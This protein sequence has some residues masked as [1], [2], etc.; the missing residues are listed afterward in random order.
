ME[1]L[2]ILSSDP[3]DILFENRNKKYGA[4]TLRKYY[5]RRLLI[6]L[7]TIFSLVVLSSLFYWFSPS[8][9]GN[10]ILRNFDPDIHLNLVNLDKKI[11]RPVLLT[12]RTI[13]PKKP[14]V[15]IFNTPL[16]VADQKAP[17]PMATVDK[18]QDQVI[19]VNN[20]AGDA[21]KGEIQ[22]NGNA[23]SGVVGQKPETEE[24][25]ETVLKIAEVMPEFPGG[26]E[27]LKRFLQKNLRM[28]DNGL[29][30]GEQ[31]KV[32]ARFVVGPDGRVRDIEIIQAAGAV[33]NQEV[34]RVIGKMP[35][36]KPGSQNQRNVAVYFNL[37]VY[38]VGSD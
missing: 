7:V 22:T 17:R 30:T 34:K 4:Y 32:I 26:I 8:G 6:S 12:V 1:P 2:A 5:P 37:P 18:I 23:E 31:V 25:K 3:L 15:T 28:P 35:D 29:E 19:G 10:I 33:F 9:S 36:W 14:A 38:F 24:K 20:L 13:V 16:I 27:A 11:E 21:D